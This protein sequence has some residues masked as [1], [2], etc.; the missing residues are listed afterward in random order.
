VRSHARLLESVSIWLVSVPETD[1]NWECAAA[2][3]RFAN[4]RRHCLRHLPIRKQN[5]VLKP[6]VRRQFLLAA[7]ALG[8][9]LQ[10]Q[11]VV[12]SPVEVTD[13]CAQEPSGET[14]EESSGAVPE[15]W[16]RSQLTGD[17]NGHRDRLE[18]SGVTVSFGMTHVF[19]GVAS[20]GL[21]GPLFPLLSDEGDTGNTLGGDLGFEIDTSSAGW[22]EGGL[23]KTQL[24]ART[25]RSIL[26]RAGTVAAVN[27]E[28]V[29][30]IVLDRFDGDA[31]AITELTYEHSLDESVSI[32]GGLMNTSLGDENAIA[33]SALSHSHFLNFAMLYSMVE[34]ATVPHSALGAGVNL[35]PSDSISGSFSV[36]GS[37]ETAGENPFDLW[38]GTTF[39]TEWTVDHTVF[40]HDG[41]QT[42]GVLYGI[43]ARRTD[44]TA[45]PRLVLISILT[46]V[47]IPTTE[48]DTWAFYYNAHQFLQGDE[49]RGWGL[50]TRFGI[51]DGNPNLVRWN[52]AG[53]IGGVGL[54]PNRL[55]DSWGAGTFVVNLSDEDLLRGLGITR[56]TGAECYYNFQVSPAVHI[57]LDAQVI[58]SG[59]PRTDTTCVFGVRTHLD[60]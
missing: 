56:E 49:D 58:E 26:E 44:I 60:F 6:A 46:G 36:F 11:I 39:S 30:P 13:S 20:G 43:N 29:F 51:S 18:E 23:L 41:A 57:T 17:W 10:A 24:Q 52:W 15:F 40:D 31:F 38:N 35:A 9:K 22:W 59:L 53:G 47:P 4:R 8:T 54:L 48:A 32:V 3:D 1:R 16:S 42:A 55:E 7:L 5:T 37:A 33:G 25:G 19:Q 27:N 34:D 2:A 12:E 45:D 21:D 28:A 14:P 50:F